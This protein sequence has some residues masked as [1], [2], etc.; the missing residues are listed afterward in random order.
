MQRS[1]AHAAVIAVPVLDSVLRRAAGREA[2]LFRDT[3]TGLG[4]I[5]CPWIVTDELLHEVG[6][7]IL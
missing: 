1:L 7:S 3:Y 4:G 2:R 6:V 5:D